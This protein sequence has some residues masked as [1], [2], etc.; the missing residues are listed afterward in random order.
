[1]EG[2]KVE[3][4]KEMLMK[5]T[6]DQGA[7]FISYDPVKG[8]WKFKDLSMC[9]ETLSTLKVMQGQGGYPQLELDIAHLEKEIELYSL[10]KLCYEAQMMEAA[11]IRLDMSEYIERQRK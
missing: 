8:E 1:M 2:P 4:Y 6:Q 9:K 11:M 5:K 10:E 3:K 7:R